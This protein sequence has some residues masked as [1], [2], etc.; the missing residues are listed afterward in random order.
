MKKLIVCA[1]SLFMVSA[2]AKAQVGKYRSDLAIGVNGGLTMNSVTFSPRIQQ[3]MH[4]GPEVGVSIR[5][6]C[7][8]YFAAVCALQA[9]VNFTNLGWR[10]VPENGSYTY[11]RNMNYIQVPFMTRMGFGRERK[12]A[13]GYIIL[14]PQ[15]GFCIGEND[16]RSGEWG[17]ATNPYDPQGPLINVPKNA[18][19]AW[20]QYNMA[21]EK[22]FQYGI[23]GGAG[24]EFSHPKVGHF[25]LEGRYYFG[26]SDIFNNGKKDIFGRSANST[27]T[28]K[29]SYFIDVKKT[30]DNSIK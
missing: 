30:K 10:E 17:D 24:V 29:L 9:E 3:S 1:C 5:Y 22:K 21:I 19:G 14:G 15:L 26:L 11:T 20:Q 27:I 4:F 13:M 7:E 8:K 6:T 2:F 18:E 12:G 16:I 23:T 25:A 28:V